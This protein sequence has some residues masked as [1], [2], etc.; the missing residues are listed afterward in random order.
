MARFENSQ[1]LV[2]PLPRVIIHP[3]P[4]ADEVAAAQPAGPDPIMITSG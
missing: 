2:A 1:V 4:P 3:N